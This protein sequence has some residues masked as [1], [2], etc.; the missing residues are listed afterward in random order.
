MAK[1]FR[2]RATPALLV[3][4]VV[5][6]MA[7]SEA[8]PSSF[9]SEASALTETSVVASEDATVR[10]WLPFSNFGDDAKLA[11]HGAAAGSYERTL[12][13]FAG[14]EIAKQLEGRELVSATL[15]LALAGKGFTLGFSAIAAHRMTRSWNEASVTWACRNETSP[16]NPFKVDCAPEDRWA[17]DPFLPAPRPY[18]EAATDTE[19]VFGWQWTPVRFDVT[20]DVNAMLGDDVRA[21]LSFMLRNTKELNGV[22]VDFHSTESSKPPKLLL[23]TRL[24]PPDELVA[25]LEAWTSELIRV[26]YAQAAPGFDPNAAVSTSGL[27]Q[28][29]ERHAYALIDTAPPDLGLAWNTDLSAHI[30]RLGAA[31]NGLMVAKLPVAVGHRPAGR[32]SN[33]IVARDLDDAADKGSFVTDYFRFIA[34]DDESNAREALAALSGI[35]E[36]IHCLPLRDLSLL[37]R[38]YTGALFEI[39]KRL[40]EKKS[41]AAAHAFYDRSLPLSFVFFDA[42]KY[43]QFP[44]SLWAIRFP[45]DPDQ[46]LPSFSFD[47]MSSDVF[48]ITRDV[49]N[50]VP[51]QDT[52]LKA[53]YCKEA[54]DQ[55]GVFIDVEPKLR[56]IGRF[57][58]WTE[59]PVHDGA[60][61]RLKLAPRGLCDSTRQ[62]TEPVRLGAGDC[63]LYEMSQNNFHC[64]STGTCFFE[65]LPDGG[66][67]LHPGSPL[68]QFGTNRQEVAEENCQEGETIPP[69]FTP[70]FACI[71]PR[72]GGGFFSPDP[73]QDRLM[74]CAFNT[75]LGGAITSLSFLSED[76]R[77]KLCRDSFARD[78]ASSSGGSSGNLPAN[79]SGD[80]TDDDITEKAAEEAAK[81]MTEKADQIGQAAVDVAGPGNAAPGA[82]QDVAA[83]VR[84]AAEALRLG[85]IRVVARDLSDDGGR[86]GTLR[87]LCCGSDNGVPVIWVDPAAIERTGGN[88]A[89]VLAHEATHEAMMHATRAGTDTF[90]QAGKDRLNSD[91][92]SE[93]VVSK[94][95][96][97]Q[98]ADEGPCG[99]PQCTHQNSASARFASCLDGGGGGQPLCPRG[100]IDIPC[101]RVLPPP[102]GCFAIDTPAPPTVCQFVLCGP[103]YVTSQGSIPLP[104]LS[105][106]L[107]GDC[108]GGSD[109][110]PGGGGS[111]CDIR[112]SCENCCIKCVCPEPGFSDPAVPEQ[113]CIGCSF[114]V[115]G[116]E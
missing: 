86:T 12:L 79:A 100:A 2:W 34:V 7:G 83:L 70:K 68:T 104:Q 89:D 19:S 82:A 93:L 72:R 26:R 75:R 39:M 95:G 45:I 101:K 3:T 50:L 23:K 43:F 41:S 15:E 53:L 98:C 108:C 90:N 54:P 18:V 112:P 6:C 8:E 4:A 31:L 28:R 46:G 87:G 55:S 9:G 64:A 27:E 47:A 44:L 113:D 1:G 51:W 76:A 40:R 107:A 52:L 48:T 61:V 14:A 20:A 63:S 110:G 29:I 56:T 116:P 62:L 92:G 103:D 94:G 84:G 115:P 13:R 25:D 17:M 81:E 97:I 71:M 16:T 11:V 35:Q 85:T 80:V 106:A 36:G 102:S 60:L 74:R 67:R 58:L 10:Q 30:Q 99:N 42:T 66:I 77:N 78:G 57:G 65:L 111:L 114:S 88:L 69:V 24:K 38:G 105:A 91:W 22:W 109:P 5:G 32:C 37:E 21:D 73:E 33:L 96:V 59:D 49:R